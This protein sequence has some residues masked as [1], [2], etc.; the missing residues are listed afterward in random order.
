VS[1]SEEFACLLT[2]WLKGSELMVG[3]LV[4]GDSDEEVPQEDV[5]EGVY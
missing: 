3:E 2:T 1:Y 4:A 5:D